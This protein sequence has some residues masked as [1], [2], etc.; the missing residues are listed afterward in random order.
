MAMKRGRTIGTLIA[1]V[2]L[3]G[4]QA[5]GGIVK[6]PICQGPGWQQY[7]EVSGNFVVWEDFRN[8]NWDIYGKDL[9]TGV[10]FPVCTAIYDQSSPSV[11]GD[12]VVW[13]DPRQGAGDCTKQII[14]GYNLSTKTEFSIPWEPGYKQEGPVVSG[15]W[16]VYR[17]GNVQ[18]SGYNLSTHNRTIIAQNQVRSYHDI[19]NSRVVWSSYTTPLDIMGYDLAKGESF[20]V[21]LD[22]AEQRSPVISG[23]IVVWTDYRNGN[24]DIYGKDLSSGV[25]F[26]ICTEVHDQ[27]SVDISGDIVVWQD[28][29]TG[30]WRIYGYDL[31]T[32][33]GTFYTDGITPAI[34]GDLL[35]WRQVDDIY[36]AYIPEPAS[37]TILFAGAGLLILR[38]R[39]KKVC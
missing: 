18:V 23:N 26:P 15:D 2:L 27:S 12:I 29:R 11:N 17:E 36:G 21:C 14:Y 9:S 28:N 31:I 3:L 33:V 32:G 5:F 30:A 24:W 20:S 25:E 39:L 35:I 8:G 4:T 7:P 19:Y 16:I 10:E 6:F 38:R 13:A 37:L 1:V 22:I 34:D